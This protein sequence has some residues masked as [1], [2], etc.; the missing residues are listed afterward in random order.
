MMTKVGF[1]V[2]WP[3]LFRAFRVSFVH[4]LRELSLENFWSCDLCLVN[5]SCYTDKIIPPMVGVVV[6]AFHG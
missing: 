4:R 2:V 5:L 6:F 3:R 1:V